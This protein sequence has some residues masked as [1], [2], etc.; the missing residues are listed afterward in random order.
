MFLLLFT[1]PPGNKK[2]RRKMRIY[3]NEEQKDKYFLT[4]DIWRRIEMKTQG[5]TVDVSA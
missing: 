1:A 3:C 5:Q 4:G 2:T